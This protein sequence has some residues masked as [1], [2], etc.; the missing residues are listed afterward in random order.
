MTLSDA[1]NVQSAEFTSQGVSKL[2]ELR[3]LDVSK[4]FIATLDGLDCLQSLELLNLA[5]N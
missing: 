3:E 5:N 1:P 4:N 2:L